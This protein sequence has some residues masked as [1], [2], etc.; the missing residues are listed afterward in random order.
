VYSRK[1]AARGGLGIRYEE[2]RKVK[3][4]GDRI[5]AG[6]E[7]IPVLPSLAR[8]PREQE[9]IVLAFGWW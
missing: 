3:R 8:K 2:G 4:T 7:G 9:E 6:R 1:Q 5:Y